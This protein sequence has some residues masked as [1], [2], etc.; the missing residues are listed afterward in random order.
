MPKFSEEDVDTFFDACEVVTRECEWP[1]A[2]WPLLAQCVLKAKVQVAFAAMDPRMGL[3]YYSLKK[4]VLAA[5]GGFPEAYRP[6]F[7]TVK[8][9]GGE[10]YLDLS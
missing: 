2:K 8:W 7:R 1:A 10:S 9:S 3:D 5:Y 6:R 4:A